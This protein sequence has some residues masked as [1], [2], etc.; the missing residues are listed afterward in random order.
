MVE[1]IVLV[2]H[3]IGELYYRSRHV[4]NPEKIKVYNAAIAALLGEFRRMALALK[5]Y[6]E[7]TPAKHVTVVRQQNLA[8][9]Q[10]V[11][12]VD[13]ELPSASAASNEQPE[14]RSD[15]ELGS[16][17]AIEHVSGNSF[18]SKRQ[19]RH[20]R[21][22]EP[23]AAKR[24]ERRRAEEA[25]AGRPDEPALAVLQRSQNHPRES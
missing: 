24:P 22:K 1:Q 15:S 16:K 2:H 11:A 25:A 9:S 14:N 7:P 6:R 21:E 18:P 20:R 10:Q 3:K 23:A 13:G 8:Q 5:S 17:K 19:A 4:N 12:Y